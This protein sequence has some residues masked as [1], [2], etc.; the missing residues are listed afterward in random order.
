MFSIRL[1]M[2]CPICFRQLNA[3]S[4]VTLGC[5]HLLCQTCAQKW[6]IRNHTCP[7]CR[8]RSNHYNRCLRSTAKNLNV[9]IPFLI[10]LHISYEMMNQGSFTYIFYVY[11]HLIK[12]FILDHLHVWY[13][14]HNYISLQEIMKPILACSIP[15]L[16]LTEH[17][18]KDFKKIL[19]DMKKLQMIFKIEI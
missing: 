3:H 18:H 1:A 7:L 5:Q 4:K 19:L 8:T 2:D 14:P 12:P 17:L 16:M 13:P 15:L 6:I 11:E 10:E 9:I